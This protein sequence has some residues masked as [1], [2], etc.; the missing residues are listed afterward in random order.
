MADECGGVIQCILLCAL[1]MLFAP[2]N[3][4]EPVVDKLNRALAKAL[5]DPA[6]RRRL[7]DLGGI[8]PEGEARSPKA[9]GELVSS[10]IVKWSAID[11]P[12][13]SASR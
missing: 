13:D 5:D 10:E 9:L 12:G 11:K 7:L 6:T 8:P 4:P 3:T 2:K 1:R